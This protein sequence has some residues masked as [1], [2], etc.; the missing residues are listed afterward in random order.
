MRKSQLAVRRHIQTAYDR[1]YSRSQLARKLGVQSNY[2]SMLKGKGSDPSLLPP[3]L[4]PAMSDICDL[5][6]FDTLDLI[7]TRI[8]ESKGRRIEFPVEVLVLA[9][10]CTVRELERRRTARVAA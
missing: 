5:T 9:I 1:G 3:S 10:S 4:I 2:V 6:D 8:K 7:F